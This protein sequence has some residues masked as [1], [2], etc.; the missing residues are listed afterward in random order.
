MREPV[1]KEASARHLLPC[2]VIFFALLAVYAVTAQRGVGWQDSGFYQYRVLACQMESRFGL[3]TAH[4]LY[5]GVAH[6]FS[7][8]FPPALHVYAINLFSG[9][10]MASAAALL[11]MLVVRLTGSAAAAWVAAVTLGLAHMA[12]WLSTIAEVY[13]WSL[14]LLMAELLCLLRVVGSGKSLWWVA[15]AFVNGV[16]AS[17]HDVAFLS[18]P[19]YGAVWLAWAIRRRGEWM[20]C[21]AA[22]AGSWLLGAAPIV[23]LIGKT[24]ASCGDGWGVLS[25][26]FFGDEWK[27]RVLGGGQFSRGLVIA[28]YALAGVSIMSPCWLLGLLGLA[29]KKGPVQSRGT[30]LSAAA[31]DRVWRQAL[32]GLTVIH[33][34]FWGRYFVP[35]QA[36]FVLPTLGLCAVW[37][38]LGA[39]VVRKWCA[40]ALLAVGI[41]CQVTLPPVLTGFVRS[42]IARSRTLPFRDEAR[43][44]LVPWKQDECSAQRFV[45]GVG[46]QLTDRDV[47]F[48]DETAANPISVARMMGTVTGGWRLVS[49]WSGEAE[50]ETA[51]L[52]EGT[53]RNGGRVFVVSP[54]SGY[55]PA[56]LLKGYEYAQDGVLWRVGERK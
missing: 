10:G 21:L 39:A 47:L 4:P 1:C 44:W 22:C 16:H 14:A 41:A 46:R 30:A 8:M 37:T 17:V 52:V 7:G 53:L 40:W 36:T 24:W 11:F 51:A 13:T 33:G 20:G 55:A 45:E 38:G 26:L 5:V 43:Y 48:A 6:L 9:V 19:V 27:D 42:H 49:V 18:L 54:M 3:A 23:L 28:N 2:A 25:S 12:W 32:L 29:N 34:L 31:T 56:S 15:L 50:A 35:D